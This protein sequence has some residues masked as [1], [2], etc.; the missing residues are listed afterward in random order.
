MQSS[1]QG[2]PRKAS[3]SKAPETYASQ[4]PCTSEK[5]LIRYATAYLKP[6][7]A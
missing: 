1:G 6:I 2:W 3:Q 4:L 7:Y 5:N